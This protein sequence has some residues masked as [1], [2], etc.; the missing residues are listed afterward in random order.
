MEKKE[1][2]KLSLWQ[3]VQ[4]LFC[5]YFKRT[6]PK[7]L[8]FGAIDAFSLKQY[9]KALEIILK[10]F[11]DEE[12][13]PILLPEN[14]K[15]LVKFYWHNP[16]RERIYQYVIEK[17]TDD[18]VLNFFCVKEYPVSLPMV[19]KYFIKQDPE[20]FFKPYLD[21]HDWLS[22]EVV[23][24]LI[25]KK[26][27][28]LLCIYIDSFKAT[29]HHNI[30]EE[31]LF[32]SD[33]EKVK[34]AFTEKFL[35][36]KGNNDAICYIMEYGSDELVTKLLQKDRLYTLE[37]YALLFD[38][39]DQV[40]INMIVENAN[41]SQQSL[42]TEVVNT[43]LESS[44]QT[45]ILNYIKKHK[46][47]DGE[48][49]TLV[50][51]NNTEAIL[52]YLKK[53]DEPLPDAF[54]E[55]YLFEH[56]SSEV[57]D[58]YRKNFCLP[59]KEERE[60]IKLGKNPEIAQYLEK[61]ALADMNDLLLIENGT[62]EIIKILLEKYE[63]SAASEVMLIRRDIPILI[64]L[65]ISKLEEAKKPFS[66]VAEALFVAKS[67]LSLVETYLKMRQYT[68]SDRA[69]KALLNR[70]DASLLDTLCQ[71][72]QGVTLEVAKD[73]LKNGD[74]K[75]ILS[76]M[77]KGF[78]IAPEATQVALVERKDAD[79]LRKSFAKEIDLCEDAEVALLELKDPSLVKAYLS[80]PSF[81][82]RSLFEESE[83]MLLD[84][85][86]EDLFLFY[87][88]QTP[89]YENNEVE[90]VLKDCPKWLDAYVAKYNLCPAASN[91]LAE[92]L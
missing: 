86:N 34:Q 57:L 13:E 11:T 40:L 12:F 28:D 59:Y 82:P 2:K 43:L 45:Q 75:T 72:G 21:V 51:S 89:L 64:K 54:T 92:R 50:K 19:E 23:D 30:D 56:A 67:E 81:A 7:E 87:I 60:L 3:K 76:Y 37:A 38:R 48:I 1:I 9:D 66:P 33:M 84:L 42:P 10:E 91:E 36:D 65:Y 31:A 6:V 85:N 25:E 78:F 83:E 8:R 47:E 74:K 27:E 90:L 62:P 58:Y 22:D 68:L 73:F 18:E 14:R 80:V 61:N 53:S 16:F 35:D 46:L 20:K 79:L 29:D 88:K 63:I 49:F 41:N 5:L 39:R 71:K 52:T 24:F 70:G 15:K 4:L 17:A 32:A 44:Y 77:D 26:Q 55:N 69:Q